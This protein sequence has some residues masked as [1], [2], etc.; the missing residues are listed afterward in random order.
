MKNRMPAKKG[1]SGDNFLLKNKNNKG[2]NK[3]SQKTTGNN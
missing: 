2:N 3:G 1:Q